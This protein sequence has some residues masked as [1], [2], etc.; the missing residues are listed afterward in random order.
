[1][2]RPDSNVESEVYERLY[3]PLRT[4]Q[5]GQEAL[6]AR[7][8]GRSGSRRAGGARRRLLF[9]DPAVADAPREERARP[10]ATASDGERPAPPWR[11]QAPLPG[12]PAAERAPQELAA[13]G[14]GTRGDA[15]GAARARRVNRWLAFLTAPATAQS[16]ERGRPP[17]PATSPKPPRPERAPPASSAT[18]PKPPRRE[19]AASPLPWKAPAPSDAP[20]ERRLPWLAGGLA[21]LLFAV[22]LVGLLVT[23]PAERSR[24]SGA[25]PARTPAATTSSGQDGPAHGEDGRRDEPRALGA[26]HTHDPMAGTGAVAPVPTG[27]PVGVAQRE[28]RKAKRRDERE[29]KRRSKKKATKPPKREGRSRPRSRPAPRGTQP[30][31]RSRSPGR[32][33]PTPSPDAAEPPAGTTPGQPTPPARSGGRDRGRAP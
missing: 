17:P 2:T 20:F 16:R 7:T 28:E 10:A 11:A 26:G 14:V 30:R 24:P 5:G 32:T 22:V 15:D 27:R 25:P 3:G 8:R 19:R 13:T 29:A 4:A 31:R 23:A 21:A 12:D 6:G 9:V 33:A 1:M 18:P